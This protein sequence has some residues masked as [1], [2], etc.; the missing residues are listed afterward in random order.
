MKKQLTLLSVLI[1]FI[2][3]CFLSGCEYTNELTIPEED[4]KSV[5]QVEQ[6]NNKSGGVEQ[7]GQIP[8]MF[9]KIIENNL[10]E[11]VVAFDE[12]LLTTEIC[13][14]DEA[15]RTVVHKIHM[16]DLYGNEL[17]SYTLG[18]DD[19]YHV[20]TLTA[21]DD[22]GFLFVLGFQDYAYGQNAW[23]SDKGVASRVIKCDSRGNLQFD[24]S[25]EGVEG[26][27][28]EYCFENNGQ[29][30]LFGTI[31]TPE[32]KTQG[33]H[34][35]TDIYMAILAQG[36]TITET[37][38][39]AGSDYDRLY[40]AEESDNCFVL[41]VSS[42][43]N[44]GDFV[45]LSKDGSPVDLIIKVND[46]FEITEKKKESGR[47]FFDYRIGEKDGVPVHKTN[48]L[49]KDF[50]AGTPEIFIDY[51]DFYM[52]VSENITGIYENTPP[53][54]SSIWYYTETVY[55][56]YDYNGKLIFRASVDSSPDYDAYIEIFDSQS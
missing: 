38:Y 51:G 50:D 41:S 13:S 45:G 5:G 2:Y 47:D 34:S 25:F 20:T 6:D 48:V 19:A 33:V 42:Q 30:Y 29:F 43:S 27:A 26:C 32:A 22:G 1:L 14:R 37:K 4:D 7:V 35:S 18:S 24:T 55:S 21:T 53:F 31:Q 8:D 10:Y 40:M 16:L 52:I 11:D 12:R 46:T 9:K 17:A 56:A 54:I 15:N 39:I 49:L 23:A 36:G 44:D 3:V 28:L